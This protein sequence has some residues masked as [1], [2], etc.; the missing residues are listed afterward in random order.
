MS[1]FIVSQSKNFFNLFISHSTSQTFIIINEHYLCPLVLVLRPAPQHYAPP[2]APLLRPPSTPLLTS[3]LDV[4]C[5]QFF[6]DV[7][8]RL[9][10]ARHLYLFLRARVLHSSVPDFPNKNRTPVFPTPRNPLS[11]FWKND[12]MKLPTYPRKE[13]HANSGHQ[14]HPP[15][16]VLHRKP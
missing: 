13:K 5:S 7:L 4:P 6:L 12:I 3:S 16:Q 9:I 15:H 2:P 8:P 1:H 14:R 11:K 10:S